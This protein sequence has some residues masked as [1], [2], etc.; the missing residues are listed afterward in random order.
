V[1][2]KKLQIFPIASINHRVPSAVGIYHSLEPVQ[3]VYVTGKVISN[4]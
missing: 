1:I 4:S 3:S 2:I